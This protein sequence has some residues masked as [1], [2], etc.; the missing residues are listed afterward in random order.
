[1]ARQLDWR[2]DGGIVAFVPEDSLPGTS[3]HRKRHG[4][5]WTESRRST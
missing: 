2:S 5:N 4:F 3:S 1:M